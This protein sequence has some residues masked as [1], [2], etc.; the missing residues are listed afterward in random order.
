MKDFFK[1]SPQKTGR[2]CQVVTQKRVSFTYLAEVFSEGMQA[3]VLG[4]A[5]Q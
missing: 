3:A 5:A 1:N 4:L 2:K